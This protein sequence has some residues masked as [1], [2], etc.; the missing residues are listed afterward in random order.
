MPGFLALLML[1]LWSVP[2]HAQWTLD[3]ARDDFTDEERAFITTE[4]RDDEDTGIGIGCVN[5]SLVLIYQLGGFMLGERNRIRVRY[6]ID[7]KEASEQRSWALAGGGTAAIMPSA[8]PTGFLAEARSG[9]EVRFEAVD[10]AD[11]EV[12][13]H[14]FS[15]MGLS[16]M[17]PYLGSCYDY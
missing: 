8:L 6:R 3:S 12:R 9:R 15:L 7:Q 10:P 11:N 1:F 13:R 5:D 17:F 4:G 14:R 16:A 2:L